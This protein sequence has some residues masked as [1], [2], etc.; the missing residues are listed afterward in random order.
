[1]INNL[2]FEAII[3]DHD[4]TLIDTESADLLACQML[5]QEFGAVLTVERWA[6]KMVGYKGGYDIAFTELMQFSQNGLTKVKLRQR[7]E[8]LWAITFENVQ[9]MPGVTSLLPQL[10][11]AGY[12]LAVAT[13]SDRA[14]AT[15]W[16]MRFELLPYFQLIATSDDVAR[17]KPAPDVFLYTAAQLGVKPERCLVFEDSLPGVSAAKAAGMKVIAVPSHVTKTLDFSEADGIVTSLEEVT[18]AWIETFH[19]RS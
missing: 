18:L 17:S 9:L 8:E 4:G 13:A 3:F 6:E 10:Q 1:M 19:A 12:P 7:L 11:A 16:L 5:Y 15:R 14:W 2:V